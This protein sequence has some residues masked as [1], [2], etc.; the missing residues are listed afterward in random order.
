[1]ATS[2]WEQIRDAKKAEQAARIPAE[3]KLSELPSEEVRDLRPYAK[4]SGI[5]SE[6]ELEITDIDATTLIE[7]IANGTYSA[8]DVVTA[9]CKRA[10]IAQ[11]LTNCLTEIAF[12]EA[13]ETA[14]ALDEQYK[15][16]GKVVGP[17]HGVPMTFKECFNL[18]GYDSS[19]AYI[20]KAFNP[21]EYDAYLIEIV[22]KAG[23]VPIA[24]TNAS[25][26]LFFFCMP[27]LTSVGPANHARGRGRKQSLRQE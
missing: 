8:V 23:G 24:K 16:T 15:A 25:F 5:L 17:L 4:T 12:A 19:N 3:W 18:K 6:K 20:S 2:S 13:I 27:F 10:A 26:H 22:K 1:M 7:R 21:A 9:Y 14:K 11:Q